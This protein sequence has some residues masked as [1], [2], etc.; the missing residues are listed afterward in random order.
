M[1]SKK[2]NELPAKEKKKYVDDEAE[3]RAHYKIEMGAWRKN[4]AETKKAER[5]ERETVAMQTA[6][7]RQQAIAAGQPDPFPSMVA[8]AH[9]GDAGPNAQGQMPGVWGAYA[10]QGGQGD[11]QGGPYNPMMMGF[12][13]GFP[14]SAMQ[15][16]LS[17]LLGMFARYKEN[18]FSP[19]IAPYSV[20]VLTKCCLSNSFFFLCQ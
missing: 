4:I 6:E 3:K 7:A 13:G 15:L 1:L 14:G 9:A 16:Q 12:P 8:G 18:S 20:H 5:K 10:A 17:Q 11:Q 19:S 2:W